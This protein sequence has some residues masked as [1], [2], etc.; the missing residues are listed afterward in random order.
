M[1]WQMS[2]WL[3][4]TCFV[5]S[6]SR[7]VM[8]L[9]LTVWKSTVTPNGVPNSSFREYRLPIEAEESSMLFATSRSSK[10]E[11]SCLRK[12]LKSA[13]F[14]SGT[15]RTFMGAIAGGRLS[16]FLALGSSDDSADCRVQ[17]ECSRRWYNILP[18]PK[19]GSMTLGVYSRTC[20]V[21]SRCSMLIRSFSSSVLPVPTDGM[22]TV[23]L[24]DCFN[25]RD[26]FSRR[27]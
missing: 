19:D 20:W 22:S 3:A 18:I 2:S 23:I 24:P 6:L 11:V 7:R 9:S 17:K 12:G 8:V 5:L 14:D 25:S 27:S 21:T 4:L 26:N 15:M 16:T 10:V 13:W 1:A